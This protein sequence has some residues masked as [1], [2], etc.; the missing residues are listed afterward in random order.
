MEVLLPN[1]FSKF[2][3]IFSWFARGWKNLPSTS[4]HTLNRFLSPSFLCSSTKTKKPD[5]GVP[6]FSNATQHTRI[7]VQQSVFRN[8]AFPSKPKLP[9]FPFDSVSLGLLFLF[10]R[11][12]L[13][14]CWGFMY[15]WW[16]NFSELLEEN[17]RQWQQS[18]ELVK[19]WPSR[20]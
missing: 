11:I 18:W 10:A 13:L 1:L 15:W 8:A 2:S 17:C 19:F 3:F 12:C 7:D 20:T 9:R 5:I 4:F 14:K 6:V 16:R